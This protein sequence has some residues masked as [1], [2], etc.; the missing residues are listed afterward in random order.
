LNFIFRSSFCSQV[1]LL[2]WSRK[3]SFTTSSISSPISE[4][5]LDCSLGPLASLWSTSPSNILW[6]SPKERGLLNQGH[7]QLTNLNFRKYVSIRN[8]KFLKDMIN[9]CFDDGA[10]ICIRILNTVFYLP[11]GFELI[12]NSD[13][14]TYTNVLIQYSHLD[15][16]MNSGPMNSIQFKYRNIF[17]QTAWSS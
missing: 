16:V 5:L 6:K 8:T 4:V 13:G 2:M 14:F 17:V 12:K 15:L 10:N 1:L 7:I 3:W 11:L 9:V